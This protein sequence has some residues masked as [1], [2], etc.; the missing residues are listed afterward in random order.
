MGA[1]RIVFIVLEIVILLGIVCTSLTSA[2]T[3]ALLKGDFGGFCPLYATIKNQANDVSTCNYVI[4]FNAVASLLAMLFGI[5][6]A[7]ELIKQQSRID[8][9]RNISL[10]IGTLCGVTFLLA[11]TSACIVTVGFKS[12]CNQLISFVPDHLKHRVK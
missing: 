12:L 9:S 4:G 11:F 2:I 7:I 8:N 10:V 3:I 5:A 6:R 1:L